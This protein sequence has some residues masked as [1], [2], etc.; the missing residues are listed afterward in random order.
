MGWWKPSL[1]RIAKLPQAAGIGAL[2][3][4]GAV[5]LPFV[6]GSF[7]NGRR[8]DEDNLPPP[9][10]LSDPLP[11]VLVA[12]PMDMQQP[13]TM[14]GMEPVRGAFANKIEMQR[15]GLSAGIDPSAPSLMSPD[16]RNVIDGTRKIDELNLPPTR[17]M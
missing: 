11:E 1:G 15:S 5:A 4:G 17:G 10:E 3:A 16:G 8:Y 14:M 2:L 12:P 7:R 9:R 6:V 13:N